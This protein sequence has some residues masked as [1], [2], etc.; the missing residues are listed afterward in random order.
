V[1]GRPRRPDGTVHTGTEDGS[2]RAVSPADPTLFHMVT[3][4]HEHHGRVW[5]GSLVE[6]AVAW[7]DV[8]AACATAP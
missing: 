7:F 6:P 5:L 8:E 2:V 1:R 4:V 3:G